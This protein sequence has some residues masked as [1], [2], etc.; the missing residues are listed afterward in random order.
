[1]NVRLV[2][3][4]DVPFHFEQTTL[5]WDLRGVRGR[6]RRHVCVDGSAS[7]DAVDKRDG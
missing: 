4:A 7:V 2:A 6:V 1:V 5:L 3:V